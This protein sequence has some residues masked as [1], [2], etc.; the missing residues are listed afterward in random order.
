MNHHPP[1][2]R[3]LL[4]AFAT[5]LTWGA[6]G[7]FVRLLEGHGPLTVTAGRLLVALLFAAPVILW[8]RPQP[9]PWKACLQPGPAWTLGGLLVAYYV[10]AVI[11]FQLAPVGEVALLLTTGPL[12]LVIWRRLRGLSTRRAEELGA[13]LAFAGVVVVLLPTL[14]F[15]AGSGLRLLG[16]GIALFAAMVIAAYAGY[17]RMLGER[18]AAPD[19]LR[20]SLLVFAVG[21]VLVGVVAAGLERPWTVDWTQA[22]WLN[23]LGLG[24]IATVI[25]SI[26]YAIASARLSA[27]LT[28]T[29]NLL[30]PVIAMIAA[31]IVLDEHPSR[32]LLPGAAMVIAGL[33]LILSRPRAR[34]PR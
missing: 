28:T 16:D 33:W 3:G 10:L 13:L 34:L 30:I 19:T 29:I 31:A 17:F 27:V 15:A 23:L 20:V 11:A 1:D 21:G 24:V 32:L 9:G 14:S 7:V 5:A 12:F 4:A 18:G 2:P 8:L 25:P 26:G 22:D 6:T